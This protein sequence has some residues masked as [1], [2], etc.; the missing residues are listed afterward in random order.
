MPYL[1]I[2]T[3][4]PIR[5]GFFFGV[6]LLMTIWEW[7]APRRLLTVSKNK[8]WMSNLSITFINSILIRILFPTAAIGVAFY[9]QQN[10]LGLFNHILI[11]NN[12]FAVIASVS[13]CFVALK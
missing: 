10:H 1:L 2:Q 4:T 5:L 7:L 3:E 12:W 8:R 9:A 13:R 6:L 11:V